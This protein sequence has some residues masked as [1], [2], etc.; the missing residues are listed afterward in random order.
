M[1]IVANPNVVGA[2]SGT[3]HLVQLVSLQKPLSADGGEQ[4]GS[5][6]EPD[7]KLNAFSNMILYFLL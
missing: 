7:G 3:R 6:D 5:D 4:Y 1:G 2:R